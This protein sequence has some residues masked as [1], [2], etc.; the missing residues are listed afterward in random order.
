[1]KK[2][3]RDIGTH[4]EDIAKEYLEKD[5]YPGATVGPTAGRDRKSVV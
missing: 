5:A 4:C 2:L 3:N 1:M